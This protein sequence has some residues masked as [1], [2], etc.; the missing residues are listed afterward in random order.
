MGDR[1]WRLGLGIEDWGRRLGIGNEDRDWEL[2]LGILIGYWDWTL[3]WRL[4][5]R[6]RIGNWV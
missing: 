6:I 2:G 4:G 1:D 3:D 5:L